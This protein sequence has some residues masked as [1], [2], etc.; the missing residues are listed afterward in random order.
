M[1]NG[2]QKLFDGLGCVASLV[3]RVHSR[4]CHPAE[5]PEVTK[6]PPVMKKN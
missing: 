2:N 6:P 1:E 5:K 3:M 4:I